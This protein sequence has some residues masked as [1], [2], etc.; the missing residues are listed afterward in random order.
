VQVV[1]GAPDRTAM[2]LNWRIRNAAVTEFIFGRERVTLDEFNTIEHLSD[3]ELV[4]YR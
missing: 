1:V 2:E 3:P 4:T